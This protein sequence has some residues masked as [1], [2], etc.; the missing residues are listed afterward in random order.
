MKTKIRN[1]IVT[2]MAVTVALTVSAHGAPQHQTSKSN[3][4]SVHLRTMRHAVLELRDRHYATASH[5]AEEAARIADKCGWFREM[6]LGQGLDQTGVDLVLSAEYA[7]FAKQETR[8]RNLARHA[9]RELSR[10]RNKPALW[11]AR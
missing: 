4:S 6:P 2:A 11:I 5:L 7:H 9:V 8:A 3:C 1:I 10:V